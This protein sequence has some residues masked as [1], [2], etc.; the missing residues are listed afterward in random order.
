MRLN[1]NPQAGKGV[2]FLTGDPRHTRDLCV[3]EAACQIQFLG[4]DCDIR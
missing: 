3:Y 1:L 4:P 2:D